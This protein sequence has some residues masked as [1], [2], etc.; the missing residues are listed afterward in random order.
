MGLAKFS[1]PPIK[2]KKLLLLAAIVGSALAI[3]ADTI[4][5]VP[6]PSDL[7]DLD[8]SSYYTWGFS[9]ITIP[10]DQIIT[11]A[12]L[13]FHNINNW[14][15]DENNDPHQHLN[16]WLLDSAD[17]P[18]H[19][20]SEQGA[21][22]AGKLVTYTDA[23]GGTDNFATWAYSAKA[24]IGTYHDSHGGPGGDVI[25]LTYTFSTL[26]LVDDLSAFI[27]NG[28]NFAL[29]FDPD[30]H[31]YNDGITFTITTERK[32]VPDGGATLVLLALGL[33]AIPGLKRLLRA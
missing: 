4:T 23:D 3:R 15:A 22:P 12:V 24:H 27:A 6:S 30:C 28:N 32:S 10:A 18:S 5:L 25:D 19:S 20:G 2:M 16:S 31:Y 21:A 11:E 14:T 33:V 29:G 9:G 13:T 26:G 7:G 1:Q 8:H 17:N